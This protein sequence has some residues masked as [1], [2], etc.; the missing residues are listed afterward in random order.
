MYDELLSFLVRNLISLLPQCGMSLGCR[1]R[2][3]P[4][5]MDDSC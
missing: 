1:W 3:R 4:P 2:K 5:D